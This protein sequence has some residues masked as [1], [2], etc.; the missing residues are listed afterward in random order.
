MRQPSSALLLPPMCNALPCASVVVHLHSMGTM[1]YSRAPSGTIKGRS[2]DTIYVAFK[3]T[4][5][6]F[7]V[8]RLKW[9][10]CHE[11]IASTENR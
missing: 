2:R 9:R 10:V 8:R 6:H 7:Y 3:K 5:C 1:R 11:R 4:F